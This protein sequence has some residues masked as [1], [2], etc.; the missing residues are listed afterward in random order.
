MG[1]GVQGALPPAGARGTL[2][3]GQVIGDPPL[4]FSQKGLLIMH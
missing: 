4:P 3:G 2:S 1:M